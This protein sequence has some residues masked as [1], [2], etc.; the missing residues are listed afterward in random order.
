MKRR[1][2]TAAEK[3]FIKQ[4]AGTMRDVDVQDKLQKLS[5]YKFSLQ[6]IRKQRQLLGLWK[7]RGRGKCQIV[8]EN[9]SINSKENTIDNTTSVGIGES[10]PVGS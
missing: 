9:I 4:N 1:I 6:A 2:W 3:E 7:M 8:G 10:I 5:G